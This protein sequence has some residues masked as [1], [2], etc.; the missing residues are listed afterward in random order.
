ME[1]IK[2]HSNALQM[3]HQQMIIPIILYNIYKFM[4]SSY[5][6]FIVCAPTH[7]KQLC[8][9]EE[10]LF[11]IQLQDLIVTEMNKHVSE[12]SPEFT[13]CSRITQISQRG[14]I[15]LLTT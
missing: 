13:E 15:E 6:T 7:F 12:F 3:E 8:S 2:S 14:S 11:S 9:L 5:N 10:M 4:Y 1:K